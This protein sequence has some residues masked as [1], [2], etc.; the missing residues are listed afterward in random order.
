MFVAVDRYRYWINN[1]T[2]FVI[3]TVRVTF[4]VNRFGNSKFNGTSFAVK[5]YDD[6]SYSRVTDMMT[7]EKNDDRAVDRSKERSK[8]RRMRMK[9]DKRPSRKHDRKVLMAEESTKSWADSDSESSSSSSSSS[10]SDQ[11]EVHC[12]MADQTSDDEVFDFSNVAFTREDLVTALNDMVKEYRKLSHTFEEVKAEN[13]D[14]K[15]SSVE[16]SAVEPGDTD[17]LKIELIVSAWNQSSRSLHKLNE[18]KKLANDKSGFGFNS[19]ECSEGETSTQSQPAYDK[20]N[21][22]GFVKASMTYDS[23]ESMRYDDQSSSQSSHEGKDGIG[24]QRPESSKPSW[25][26]NRLDKDK[27]K[28]DSKSHVQHQPR[29]NFRKEKSDWKKT[30]PRRDTVGQNVKSKL[31]RSHNFA[32]TFVDPK[33]GNTVKVIQVS[34]T[35]GL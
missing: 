6:I 16:P 9:S 14:L 12:L 15:N 31:H 1:A 5:R 27:A 17:S 30:Q 28:A 24:Y 20:F 22:M 13:A 10:D 34:V 3:G 11:E 26:K 35:A 18:S 23:C 33:T 7:D 29:R 21:K 25:L 32:Q 19:S 4:D 2:V 8:D